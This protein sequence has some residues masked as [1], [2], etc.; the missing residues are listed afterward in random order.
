MP[1]AKLDKKPL[2]TVNVRTDED[3][4]KINRDEQ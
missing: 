1:I 2:E 4:V 3:Y